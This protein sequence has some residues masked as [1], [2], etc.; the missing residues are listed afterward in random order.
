LLSGSRSQLLRRH[1]PLIRAGPRLAEALRHP[2]PRWALPSGR[3]PQ[4]RRAAALLPARPPPLCEEPPL[5]PARLPDGGPADGILALPAH[6]EDRVR[7][8]DQLDVA[9]PVVAGAPSQGPPSP[10]RARRRSRPPGG[11]PA[12]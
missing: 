7:D 9:L 11:R 4:R 1:L 3:L 10:P 12:P 5:H 6:G 8:F 2:R